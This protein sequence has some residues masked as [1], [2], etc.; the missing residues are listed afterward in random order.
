MRKTHCNNS[1]VEIIH[2]DDNRY[3]I[4]VINRVF[5]CEHA[6]GMKLYCCAEVSTHADRLLAVRVCRY[7]ITHATVLSKSR[8]STY[9]LG[10]KILTYRAV[11]NPLGIVRGVG[12]DVDVIIIVT[13]GYSIL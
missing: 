9:H 8:F 10:S 6:T 1:L 4:T 3:G 11:D 2:S 12:Y 7:N 5:S 13:I